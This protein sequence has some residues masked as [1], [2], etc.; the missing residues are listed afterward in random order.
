MIISTHSPYVL[1]QFNILL[2]A[3]TISSKRPEL[4]GKV[5]SIVN[6]EFWLEPGSTVAYAIVGKRVKSILD[7]SGLIDG[8]YLDEVSGNLEEQFQSL[9]ELENQ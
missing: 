3:G 9:L 5:E 2:K 8:D 6:R 7:M 1:T 4:A